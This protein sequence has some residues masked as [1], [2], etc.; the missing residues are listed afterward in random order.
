MDTERHAKLREWAPSV[1]H[2]TE[3]L[4][5]LFVT[6]PGA[7]DP[8]IRELNSVVT[9]FGAGIFVST[10]FLAVGY[11]LFFAIFFSNCVFY[12]PFVLFLSVLS[13]LCVLKNS[14][15]MTRSC[16]KYALVHGANL[17]FRFQVNQLVGPAGE[18]GPLTHGILFWKFEMDSSC[19]RGGP[20]KFTR[21]S[22]LGTVPASRRKKRE[23]TSATKARRLGLW[24]GCKVRFVTMRI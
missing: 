21:T 24:G 10:A 14:A 9:D 2:L 19:A 12:A 4:S 6:K 8:T 5:D 13:C 11:R 20:Q 7:N 3:V 15:S 23:A 1:L 17:R 16:E 18:H 22:G